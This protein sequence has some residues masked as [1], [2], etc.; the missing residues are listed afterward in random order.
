MS[1]FVLI[2]VVC[3]TIWLILKWTEAR[4]RINSLEARLYRLETQRPAPAA[5]PSPIPQPAPEPI[6]RP[7]PIPQPAIPRAV[8]PPPPPA[9]PAP[10]V[11][12]PAPTVIHWEKFLGVKLFAWVGGL[13]LFLGVLFFVKYAFD[14][15]WITPPMQVGVG[16]LIGLGLMVG[17]LFLSRE[18]QAV[19]IQTLCATGTL[20][21]YA[22]TFAAHAYYRFFSAPFA[23]ALMAMITFAAF[24]LAVRLNAQV[25]AILGLLGGFLTPPLLSTG[26]DNPIGLFGYLALLDLGLLAVALRQR[27]NYLTLLAA[28]ATMLMQF[29]WVGKFYEPHKVTIAMTIFLGFTAL[30]VGGLGIAHRSQR[31]SHFL[32]AAALLMPSSALAFAFYLFRHWDVAG[33]LW[34]YFGYIFAADVAFLIIAW[35]RPELRL[36]Q[37]FSG[38]LVFLLLAA[39]T[40]KYLSAATLNSVLAL[41]F[42]FALIHTVF[43]VLMQRTRP[44]TGSIGWVHLFPS[45]ALVLVL[46]PLGKLPEVSWAL[47]PVVLAVNLLA[48]LLA[49]F[50]R[51]LLAIMAVLL[52]TTFIAIGWIFKVPPE[53]PQVAGLLVLIGAFAA[54]FI[55]ASMLAARKVAAQSTSVFAHLGSLSAITPFML[56]TLVLFRLPMAN[57]APVFGLAA[58]L[59]VIML[60][61]VRWSSVDSLAGVGLFSILMLEHAWHFTRFTPD[62][63]GIALAWYAGFGLL[64]LVFPFVFQK[65][66]EKR[67]ALW[68][69]SAL[70]LPLQFF[71]IFRVVISAW[72]DFAYKGLVPAILAIPCLA[73]LVR[74]VRSIPSE[75]PSRHTLLALFGGVSLFF[76]TFIFPIQ[77]ERQWLTIGWAV[78]AVALLA[79]FHT[80][81]HPGL[82]NV[83]VGLLAVCFARLALNP[84]VITEYA[85]TGTPI[86]NWYLY[87]YGIVAAAMMFGARLLAPPRNKIDALNI[88]PILYGF[89]AILAFLLLNIEIA[90]AF[91]APGAQ[92]TFNFSG[93]F[94]QDMAYSLAWAVFAFILLA[95][96]FKL[97]NAPTRYAGMGLLIFTLL[98]L[99]LH[100]LW[101]LGGLYRIG[102]L[103]GLAIVLILV[104][105]IYQ[106]F[107]SDGAVK[108]SASQ[109]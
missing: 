67:V 79:L 73:A 37:I 38:S 57:P 61:L 44:A 2:A 15:N 109:P 9:I 108:K 42:L 65:H 13:A 90:D 93:S 49:V 18:R 6:V 87:T 98:K 103:V 1:A 105:F 92:L 51:S 76:I 55:A 10:P 104:S 16:Y 89:G 99:F 5:K 53:L 56:L 21:L 20:I 62:T 85:R 83:G 33:N 66:F 88:P 63:A 32:S 107:L 52:L 72:P 36:G 58:V 19:T 26:V 101:R 102:S 25:V 23:F 74:V 75:S 11:S 86:W 106:R 80:V 43:P 71:L 41:Y 24:Y 45:L 30:F 8:A 17:C 91:S 14:K 69:I 77:L 46:V 48:V 68:A 54:F 70:A 12:R 4:E 84:W 50:T 27:W 35:L 39:W 29:G 28:V 34:L 22:T 78:E 96:G 47:W 64:F 97:N 7:P 3:A 94:A 95:I 81:P 82:R 40:G 59:I 60:A 100:D 31:H